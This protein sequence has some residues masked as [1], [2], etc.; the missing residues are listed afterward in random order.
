MDKIGNNWD[1]ILKEEFE[2]P[3]FK[4][5]TD[6][7]E[8]EYKNYTIYP[9]KDNIYN[10]LKLTPP[11]KVKVVILGQDPYINQG[12]AN[13]LA[14][15]VQEGITVPPSLKNVFRE[16]RSDL[17]IV[18][19]NNGDLTK[20]AEQGVLLLNATL[21]VRAGLS[22]SHQGKGWG[23][24]TDAIIAY[25]GQQK[26][27]I[28]FLLWGNFAKAKRKYI[29]TSKNLVLEAAHPS[30]LSATRGFFGC[31]HFSKTNEY[32]EEKELSPINWQL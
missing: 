27:G 12:Q 15:S 2:K 29:G 16:Q 9:E 3:Y 10:A 24:F 32:L 23:K 25:L 26:C 4:K 19:P 17:G 7:I 1:I 21:T 22:N 28:V 13:G 11:E 30:P 20:W 6:F 8:E 31:R 14:F 5:L 18:Q